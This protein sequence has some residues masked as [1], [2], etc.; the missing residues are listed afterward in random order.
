MSDENRVFDS[1][2]QELFVNDYVVYPGRTGSALWINY[3]IITKIE[4]KQIYVKGIRFGTWSPR[5]V[6]PRSYPVYCMDRVLKIFSGTHENLTT[7]FNYYDL[8][9]SE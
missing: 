2:G 1:I 9:K 8:I 4:N 6:E 3:S 7:I 5:E